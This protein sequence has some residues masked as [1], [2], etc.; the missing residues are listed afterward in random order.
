MILLV[1]F[2]SHQ[3]LVFGSLNGLKKINLQIL[4]DQMTDRSQDVREG[5]TYYDH[6]KSYTP[7]SYLSPFL[8]FSEHEG[9]GS[10]R[11]ERVLDLT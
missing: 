9:K 8:L 4:H 7:S 1:I 5:F 6:Y 3:R 2:S 10:T 11:L